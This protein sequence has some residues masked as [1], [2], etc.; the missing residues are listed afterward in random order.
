MTFQK[1]IS[2][3][4]KVDVHA[5]L[6]AWAKTDDDPLCEEDIHHHNWRAGPP[7]LMR[8]YHGTTHD[9]SVF[10]LKYAAHRGA[11]G[12]VH[13]FT[14]SHNDA[15]NNYANGNGPDLRAKIDDIVDRATGYPED[16]PQ[17]AGMTEQQIDDWAKEQLVGSV[18]K[19]HEL[20]VKIDRPFHVNSDV[21]RYTPVFPDHDDQY[22]ATLEQIASDH[23][24]EL[25]DVLEDD[26]LADL[27]YEKE[28][29]LADASL[30]RLRNSFD[31]ACREIGV[32]NLE[33]P[34]IDC[35]LF[36]L[37][38]HALLHIFE[39]N[40]DILT[41]EDQDGHFASMTLFSR[42]VENLGFDSIV[43]LDA[44]KK[45]SAMNMN[46]N[47]THVHLFEQTSRQ[48]KSVDN[49]GLFNPEV[50]DIYL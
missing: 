10:D 12:K 7:P 40:T 33:F 46:P 18:E 27:F 2:P 9:F 49:I 14:S 39:D 17:L 15:A 8:A 3:L 20:Y 35:S 47:T 38:H 43:I 30:N 1:D 36:E 50:A 26:T 13:Y 29:E 25:D 28:E 24:V 41:V 37:T 31:T 34:D 45:F 4:D 11:M 42:T 44:D 21:A 23:D 48:L 22:V 19:V 32:T 5:N 16:Y 6:A